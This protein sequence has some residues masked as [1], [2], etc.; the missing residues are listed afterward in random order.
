MLIQVFIL[1]KKI[2]IFNCNT[3]Y[4]SVF[5]F[6]IIK[7]FKSIVIHLRLDMQNVSEHWFSG[8][9]VVFIKGVHF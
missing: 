7:V 3:E 8:M 5:F 4:K 1:I 9:T 6:L 2:Q